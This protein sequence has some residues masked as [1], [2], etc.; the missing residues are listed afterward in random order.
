[1]IDRSRAAGIPW[2]V[3]LEPAT[4]P[5]RVEAIADYVNG[6]EAVFVNSRA[7]TRLGDDPAGR[8]FALGALRPPAISALGFWD[9]PGALRNL[10]PP[11][12]RAQS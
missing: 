4:I 6:S 10:P 5:D 3:D 9:V 11:P 8:L 12:L 7:A 2:S 1:M